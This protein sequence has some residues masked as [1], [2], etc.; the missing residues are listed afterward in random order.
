MSHIV[1]KSDTDF[2]F[3]CM[4]CGSCVSGESDEVPG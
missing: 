4:A 3:R 1:D 2:F